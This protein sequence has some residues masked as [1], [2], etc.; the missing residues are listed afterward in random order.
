[1]KFCTRRWRAALNGARSRP[2]QREE[3]EGMESVDKVI[4]IDQSPIGRT[5]RSNPAT[6]TG[7][8]EDIREPVRQHPGRQ[9]ARL[10]TRAFQL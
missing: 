5:P 2:G 8:F 1:M 4:G 6:Y 10:R 3:V 7:V 9:N